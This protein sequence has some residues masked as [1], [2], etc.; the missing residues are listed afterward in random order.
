M[1]AALL[2][3]IPTLLNGVVTAYNKSKD[4]TIASIRASVGIAQAQ[5]AAM[6]AWVG[7][8]LSPQSIL[9]YAVVLYWAKVIAYDQVISFWVTGRAGYTPPLQEGAALVS[10]IAIG[11]M[12]GSGI[13]KHWKG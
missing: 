9:C 8:P 2:G 10:S 6:T 7:H 1:L 12:F 5:A 11:G 4:V 3:F 13:T